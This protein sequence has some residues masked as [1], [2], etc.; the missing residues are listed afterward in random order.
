MASTDE[1]LAKLDAEGV[2]SEHL[3]WAWYFFSH[4]GSSH[5]ERRAFRATRWKPAGFMNLGS[6]TEGSDDR[7]W[8]H[9]SHTIRPSARDT[10]RE[11]DRVAA[12]IAAVHGVRYDEWVVAR[13]RFCAG[14]VVDA[15][16]H[17]RHVC[18]GPDRFAQ[19]QRRCPTRRIGCDL[20]RLLLGH[21]AELRCPS[22]NPNQRG[23]VEPSGY[24][25]PASVRRRRVD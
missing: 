10:L 18:V 14:R 11:A 5:R 12:S 21:A 8:H 23:S 1:E 9:W 22:G 4:F 3:I 25:G 19:W 17:R 16:R 6:D 24:G 13:S 20:D 2:A 7:Y 15:R